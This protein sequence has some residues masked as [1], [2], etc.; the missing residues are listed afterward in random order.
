MVDTFY[1]YSRQEAA[2]EGRLDAW[3]QSHRTNIRCAGDIEN[4]IVSHTREG[5]LKP[6][7]ARAALDR[8]GFQRVRFVLNS[9]LRG[10]GVQGFEPDSFLWART[11]YVPPDRENE[12]FQLQTPPP[13][14]AEFVRQAHGEYQALGLFGPEQ[15]D[16]NEPDYT[17]Q[18]L[19]LRPDNLA[20]S[21]WNAQNQLWYGQAG[22]GC[23]PAAMNQD[24][25][26][27]CLE[28]GK[29]AHWKRSDFIGALDERY[30]PDWAQER[31]EE[32]REPEQHSPVWG[33]MEM[34]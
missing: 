33:G 26:A 21:S 27:V 22:D 14:L 34:R 25:Y 19:V 23:S 10:R 29:R 24:V 32:L 13:L 20:E 1:P 4:L 8:W 12:N 5:R 15:C 18:V 3:T 7:C 6:D 11:G 28:D 16:L 2:R 31:L 9:S 17:G 30:L